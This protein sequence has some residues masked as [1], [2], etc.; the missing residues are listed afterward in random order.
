MKQLNMKKWHDRTANILLLAHTDLDGH[1][2]E[3]VLRTFGFQPK[4]INLDNEEVDLFISQLIDKFKTGEEEIPDVLLISD[5]SPSLK[6]AQK[7]DEFYQ[8][9]NCPI[10]LFDHHQTALDLNQF[11]WA[12]VVVEENGFKPCGTS[13]L[14]QF[15]KETGIEIDDL[16]DMGLDYFVDEVRLYDTWEW[17]KESFESP[18]EL[19]DLFYLIGPKDFIENRIQ[20]IQS[21]DGLYLFTTFEEN[22][23]GVEKARIKDYLKRKNNEMIIISDFFKDEEGNSLTVGVVQADNYISELGHHL[24]K[25]HSEIDF[26]I[27]LNLTRNKASLR[28]DKENVDLVPIAKR[29]NGGGH[30]HAAGCQITPMGIEF[31]QLLFEGIQ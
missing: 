23:L 11:E 26:A 28:A 21:G 9:E 7:L 19:N 5:I 8:S 17:V 30:Q 22:L 16:V 29:Y 1:G 20:H 2:N 14:Y 18:K 25:E 24:C 27:L 6:V 3:I 31:M 10:Y 4:V 15:V 13:L 12:T